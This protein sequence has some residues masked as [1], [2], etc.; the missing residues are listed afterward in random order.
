MPAARPEAILRRRFQAEHD[1]GKRPDVPADLSD[2]PGIGQG[3]D[4]GFG[5]AKAPFRSL[6]GAGIFLGL[7]R[8]SHDHLPWR[9]GL[10]AIPSDQVRART[11]T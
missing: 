10:G 1:G 3:G 4:R 7:E 9:S 11:L 5:Q 2:E 8:R 6:K